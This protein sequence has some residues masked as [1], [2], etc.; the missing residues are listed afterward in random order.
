[1]ERIRGKYDPQSGNM[2]KDALSA[3]RMVN[4]AARQISANGH[5]NH[6]RRGKAVVGAPANDRQF[7]THL[8]HRRPDVIEELNFDDWFQAAHC[9]A[10]RS[11]DNA[12]F[13]NGRIEDTVRTKFTLQAKREFEDAALA[14]Y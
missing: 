13:R 10:R 14:F 5:T 8:H 2:S 1:V 3:L 11:P 6:A 9:H 12:G 7:V 4:R